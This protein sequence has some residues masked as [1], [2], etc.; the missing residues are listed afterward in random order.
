MTR[1]YSLVLTLALL[2]ASILAGA[3]TR[4]ASNA[5]STLF[6]EVDPRA[7]AL[8][9]DARLTS[10]AIDQPPAAMRKL[11]SLTGGTIP[12][13][14]AANATTPPPWLGEVDPSLRPAVARLWTAVGAAR[15]DV[16][17]ALVAVRPADFELAR[18]A[19]AV[20]NAVASGTKTAADHERLALLKDLGTRVE[21]EV[22][23]SATIRILEATDAWR[24]TVSWS[25]RTSTSNCIKGE[26]EFESPDC[27]LV[28]GG[29]GPNTYE[30]HVAVSI[31]RGGD[32]TYRNNAGGA[33]LGHSVSLALDLGT[34][35][36]TYT[37]NDLEVAQ[38]AA[39]GGAGVLIDDG[40]NDTYEYRSKAAGLAQGAGVIGAGVLWDRGEGR[41]TYTARN[42]AQGI[43][44]QGYGMLLDE[45]GPD[46]YTIPYSFD[47]EGAQGSGCGA[48]AGALIDQ[49]FAADIY[50]ASIDDMQGMA[51]LAAAGVLYD[52]GG[53]DQYTLHSGWGLL[54]NERVVQS[55]WGQGYAELGAVAVLM[56]A[57]AGNDR[58]ESESKGTQ[59]EGANSQ[60]AA[61]SAGAGYLLDGGGDDRYRASVQA[62]G[63]GFGG[64]GTLGVLRDVAGDDVYIST[65]KSQGYGGNAVGALFDE[66]GR[67]AYRGRAFVQGAA[68]GVPGG[69]VLSDGDGIDSYIAEAECQGHA[70]L[71]VA[72]FSD[73][74]GDVDSYAC[75]TPGGNDVTWNQGLSGGVDR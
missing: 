2:V 49:G 46:R 17:R 66:A 48:G 16:A 15:A 62:Q 75:A 11:A 28:I 37:A 32:D 55:G 60:G 42:F 19:F 63:S 38:G 27:S 44:S 51:C 65:D 23:A 41:D 30:R 54:G 8:A 59:Y 14:L 20:S 56:D 29:P 52:G 69:G 6:V 70:K 57:G 50:R 47:S 67:D 22:F 7:S 40:G 64:L 34:G 43:G 73:L 21:S 35:A 1:R 61:L 74:G 72:L 31:D 53:S 5:L 9:M 10:L 39:L 3:P 4:A 18:S 68:I 71:G 36:D 58:Y 45:G 24:N 12:R 25:A 26:V 13:P 33:I